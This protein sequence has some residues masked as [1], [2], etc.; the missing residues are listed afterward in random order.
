MYCI[1]LLFIGTVCHYLIVCY[2]AVVTGSTDGIGKEYARE[3]A[4]RGMS[5]L[6]ISRTQEKLNKVATEIGEWEGGCFLSYCMPVC[7]VYMY[8]IQVKVILESYLESKVGK[9]ESTVQHKF[10]CLF[11]FLSIMS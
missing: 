4:R 6:L 11:V 2:P 10:V 9:I 5:I 7:C 3:L 8:C 1:E